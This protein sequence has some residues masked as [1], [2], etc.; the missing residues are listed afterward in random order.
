MR[1]SKRRHLTALECRALAESSEV[2]SALREPRSLE[3]GIR[4]LR[5]I[6]RPRRR[7]TAP[8]RQRSI[9]DF[10][11]I[12]SRGIEEDPSDPCSPSPPDSCLFQHSQLSVP[13]PAAHSRKRPLPSAPSGIPT[14]ELDLW[15]EPQEKIPELLQQEW[16]EL[17]VEPL[18]DPHYGLL[19]TRNWEF[20]QGSMDSLPTEILRNIFAL[21]PVLDLYQNLSLVCHSWREIIRDP[22][23]I[24]WKKLYH[25]YLKGERSALQGVE[26]ILQEFSITKENQECVLGLVRLVASKGAK[27]DPNALHRI[28][29]SHPLFPKAQICVHNKFPDLLSKPG[30]ERMWAIFAVMVL[31]S[32]GVGDIRSLLE[33]FR[34]CR[35]ELTPLEA[36]EALH[37]MATVLQAMR[38]RG[39]PVSNRIHYN[40]FYC[41]YL[42]ENSS[43]IAPPPEKG[44]EDLCSSGWANVKLTHEQQR[45]LNHKI[46]PG[47]TVKIM[48]FAGTGKTSTLVKYAEK[49][50]ELKFLYLAFNRAVVEKGKK[51]FPRNVTCKTFHSLAFGSAGRCY[52]DK[53]KLNFSKMSVFS[54][55]SLLRNCKGQSLFVRAKT[56]AQTLENFFSSMDEEISEEHVPLWFRN[57]HGNVERVSPKEKRINVEEAREIWHN[58]KELDGDVERKYKMTCD[59]Y[60]KLWQLS[61]PQLSGYDAI[62]VDEAQDCTPAI[63][64]IVQSQ[65]CGKILVGDPHQQIYTF[66]GA[67]NTLY[68][69]PH[70]HVFY[71]TQSFRFGPEIAYVGSTILDLCKGIRGK[72][73]LGG[74]QKGDV[75]GSWAGSVALLSR[76]NL[77]VF[78]D[79]VEFSG[80]DPP[81]KIHI[82]GGLQRFGLGRILDIWKLSQP[83]ELRRNAELEIDD[84]FIRRWEASGGLPALR[85]FAA[86]VQ[87]RDLEGKI[88]IVEKYRERIPE[89]LRRIRDSHVS[90]ESLADY[91]LGTVHQAKGQE[92]DSVWVADDF[93]QIPSTAFLR[94]ASDALGQIP[95]DEWNLLYVAVT[96]ARKCLLMSKS[97]ENLLSL[98]R[99][100]FLRVE[101]LSEAPPSPIPCCVLGCTKSLEFCSGLVVKK[102]PLSRSDGSRDLGGFLCQDC[103][104]QLFGSLAPLVSFPT[105]QEKPI[106]P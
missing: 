25:R 26:Q 93:V 37:C 79:A 49:F 41:L 97:L 2:P 68:S 60:L 76:S 43:G 78:E 105:I 55:S 51:V 48:A 32:D 98:A 31:F 36:T 11:G 92:F 62:F 22:L 5:P 90:R 15:D 45:I 19:G 67:V 28:L 12:R 18:P 6:P 10:C 75:R 106:Q 40:I 21:L 72:T 46:E 74:T 81:A 95:E 73:L 104:Q 99:E 16:E 89:L 29:G 66:R 27:V 102:L 38:D 57:T 7:S 9:L 101:L 63:V 8:G 23:F 34:S 20:P 88:S 30:P 84:P 70:S 80:R 52:K 64:D 87:D 86:C 14:P 3:R 53:G 35:S 94:R 13:P 96:R 4:G 50:P 59:G 58:M 82:I 71:L 77:N 42:M 85:E 100:H 61:K 17:E 83:P 39:I 54:I 56:V 91:L 1:R 47:Q 65:K 103:T 44:R 33:Y 69:L 24:P